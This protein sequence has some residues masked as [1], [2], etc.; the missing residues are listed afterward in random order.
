[1]ALGALDERREEALQLASLEEKPYL[2]A[3]GT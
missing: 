1:M 3:H 2:E